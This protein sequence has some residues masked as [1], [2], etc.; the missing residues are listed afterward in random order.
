MDEHTF[1]REVAAR[2]GC[3]ERRAQGL[4]LA[5]LRTLRDR[6]TPAEAADVAAQLPTPLKRLWGEEDRSDRPVRKTHRTE[7]LG[8]VRNWAGLPDD[9]EAERGVKAVFAE[10]QK[11]LG[12]RTGLEGETWDIFSQLPKDMK[13]LWM[14]AGVKG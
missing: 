2:L 11:V 14:T 12:S 10:L 1:I 4:T 5:V 13:G 6:L 8:L 9:G 3:D 7:F